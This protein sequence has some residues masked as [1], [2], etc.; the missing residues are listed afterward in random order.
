MVD[1]MKVFNFQ[2]GLKNLHQLMLLYLVSRG[3]S[4][5]ATIAYPNKDILQTEYQNEI[6]FM[7][8]SNIK[9]P[10]FLFLLFNSKDTFSETFLYLVSK[11]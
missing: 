7:C 4:H 11:L 1:F 10:I 9:C 8:L 2:I 3:D 6:L 5:N